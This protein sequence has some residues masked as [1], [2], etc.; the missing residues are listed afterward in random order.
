MNFKGVKSITSVPDKIAYGIIPRKIT[1]DEDGLPLNIS[2]IREKKETDVNLSYENGLFRH[3]QSDWNLYYIDDKI[4]EIEGNSRRV[5]SIKDDVYLVMR[6]DTFYE[7]SKTISWREIDIQNNTIS[8]KENGGLNNSTYELTSRKNIF[9]VIHRVAHSQEDNLIEKKGLE[10][11]ETYHADN[12][13]LRWTFT[14][15]GLIEKFLVNS[16]DENKRIEI[17]YLYEY[18]K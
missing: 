4:I 8:Y 17:T 10:V 1:F 5:Y 15:K 18:Y 13:I 7:D 3:R 16:L 11:I 12:T 2:Y 14:E 6:Q 9:P